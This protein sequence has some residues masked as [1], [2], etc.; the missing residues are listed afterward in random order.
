MVATLE[1]GTWGSWPTIRLATPS[2]ELEVVGEL[3]ARVISLRDRRH[4]REWLLAGPPP[5]ERDAMDW[6]AESADFSGPRAFGW[7]ECLPTVAPCAD[8]R[9]LAAPPLRDHGDQWGRG[10]IVRLDE[11][12]GAVSHTW[13][14]PRWPYRLSRALSCPDD[15]TVLAEYEL[16]S[17]ADEALPFGWSAHPVLGLEPGCRIA[18]PGVERV[19][20]TWQHEIDLPAEAGWPLASTDAGEVDLAVVRTGAGWA[21][22]LYGRP[23][24][25]VSVRTPAGASLT[26]D[27][28]RI[29]APALRVWLAYGGW[30]V[31]G[32]PVE[33]VAL[34]PTTSEDD[35]L[36]GALAGDRARWL[37]PG[38]TARWWLSLRVEEDQA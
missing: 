10:A 5:S 27:W 31:E 7:D 25:P 37:A 29:V 1:H 34:E 13:S 19:R 23:S 2:L 17:L 11:E 30:P 4:A 22:N 6:G 12:R 26:F 18:L 14:A 32:P 20:R 35:D 9:D 8:P 24:G 3:G 38:E 28:D 16:R 15:V 36:A 21:A 33:Q